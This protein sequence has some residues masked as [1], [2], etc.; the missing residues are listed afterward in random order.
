[1]KKFRSPND[2]EKKKL[3]NAI[4]QKVKMFYYLFGKVAEPKIVELNEVLESGI[5]YIG[6][7]TPFNEFNTKH[8][9]TA[10]IR[11]ELVEDNS[12]LYQI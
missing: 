9:K 2:E 4:G 5:G 10:I 3:N 12:V 1:M 8:S 11:I 7:C 6:G